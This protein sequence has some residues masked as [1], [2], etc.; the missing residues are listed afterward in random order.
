MFLYCSG[1]RNMGWGW[2]AGFRGGEAGR[3][4]GMG[5]WKHGGMEAWGH[6]GMEPWNIGTCGLWL[7]A[8]S[9]CETN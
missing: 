8:E 9:K 5:A 6:G 1:Q 2:F 4:G 3:H 7:V